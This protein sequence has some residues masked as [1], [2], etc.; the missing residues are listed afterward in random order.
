MKALVYYIS[1]PF[2]YLISYLPFR[3]MYIFSDLLFILVYHVFGYRK[4]VVF[5]NLKKSFPEKT[6]QE[7]KRIALK[8]YRYFC[9]LT[10]ETFKSLTITEASLKKRISFSGVDIFEDYYAKNQSTIIA[11]GHFGNWELGGAR[12]AVEPLHQLFVI[13]HPLR[14][15]YFDQLFY[16]MR[17]RL[18][19]GLYSMK[20]SIRGIIKDRDKLTTIAFIADQTPSPKGAHWMQF[21]NQET[22]V[23]K[24]MGKIASKMD[25]PV[26]YV[27]IQRTGRGYYE[28][29]AETLIP[30]PKEVTETEIIE[31]FTKRLEKDIQEMPE[32]WLWTH[33]RW[34]HKKPRQ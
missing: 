23:F 17:T 8:F 4:K 28:M 16:T 25:Y 31:L 14:N 26:I 12:F 1:L 34:K 7:I 18:G 29:K 3:I 33:R 21:L 30:S 27:G 2:I 11:M 20:E 15:K 13:Y 9:D 6:D 10:F 5:T 32:I 22:P 19:N 24:G